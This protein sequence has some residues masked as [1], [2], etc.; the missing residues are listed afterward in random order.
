[1][2]WW[3][4]Q[5]GG[6][7][8]KKANGIRSK[9]GELL[10]QDE[11]LLQWWREHFVG[12]YKDMCDISGIFSISPWCIHVFYWCYVQTLNPNIEAPLDPSPWHWSI[13]QE[14]AFLLALTSRL[15]LSLISRT[16]DCHAKG[17]RSILQQK[18]IQSS[19]CKSQDHN[20]H[21]SLWNTNLFFS[22]RAWNLLKYPTIEWAGE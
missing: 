17:P 11:K 12:I 5:L 8:R 14:C 3:T 6:I 21:L 4:K 20:D 7:N 16:P 19:L 2:S 18:V 22:S 15:I 13:L 1:M 10:I 9:N